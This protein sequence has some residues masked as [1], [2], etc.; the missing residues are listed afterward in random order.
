MISAYGDQENYA[1][2]MDSGAKSFFT[3]PIDFDSLKEEVFQLI[4]SNG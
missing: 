3:K 4:E 1:R 2:A